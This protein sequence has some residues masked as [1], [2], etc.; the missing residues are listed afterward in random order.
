MTLRPAGGLGIGCGAT[1]PYP[2]ARR[3]KKLPAKPSPR[4]PKTAAANGSDA[5][6]ERIAAALERL[7]GGAPAA[8]QLS[9]ADAFS[10]HPDGHRLV[11]V[12]RVNR[13]E[14][15]LLRGI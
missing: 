14:M 2:M 13:V 11:P 8:P 6:L 3:V 10:W 15:S 7:A 9:S 1:D 12:A 5:L 4:P